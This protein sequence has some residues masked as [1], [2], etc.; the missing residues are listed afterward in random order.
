MKFKKAAV[1]GTFD[2]LHKGHKALLDRAFEIAEWV[3]IGLTIDKFG[4]KKSRRFSVRK[5]ELE[6][7]LRGRPYEVVRLKDPYGSAITDPELDAIVVSEETE[8]RAREINEMREMRGLKPL[9]IIVVPMVLAGDGLPI[10]ST[11]IREGVID[12]EGNPL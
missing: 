3:V 8:Y 1:G 10:S 9:K 7:Y 11:R 6:K 12:E 2:G 5:K 4:G